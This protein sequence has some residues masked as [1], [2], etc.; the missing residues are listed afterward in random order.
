M[1]EA[2]DSQPPSDNS[3]RHILLSDLMAILSDEEEELSLA[4]QPEP[5]RPKTTTFLDLPPTQSAPSTIPPHQYFAEATGMGVIVPPK[6]PSTQDHLEVMA[7]LAS[8]SG[9]SAKAPAKVQSTNK[10]PTTL[11]MPPDRASVTPAIADVKPERPTPSVTSS[12]PDFSSLSDVT[13]E[14]ST[15]STST[16]PSTLPTASTGEIEN[17]VKRNNGQLAARSTV[18]PPIANRSTALV[19]LT[20]MP[21]EEDVE[22]F[23]HLMLQPKTLAELTQDLWDLRMAML[24]D[25]DFYSQQINRLKQRFWGLIGI[26]S[27]TSVLLAAALGWVIVNF[28]DSQV[29]LARYD[30]AI[31]TNTLLLEELDRST[32]AQL[33]AKVEELQ[34]QVPE[35][36]NEDLTT[37]QTDIATLKT[38]VEELETSVDAHDK[39]L[40]VLV[41]AFQGLVRR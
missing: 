7:V 6:K 36:L 15:S 5:L 16:V 32:M 14:L 8:P 40:S 19:E 27:G 17:E 21:P 31:A 33:A 24:S 30:D 20:A 29:R 2:N 22:R 35:T 37:T 11:D 25:S 12:V 4:R 1:V 34:S 38:Q 28:Q 39:A 18:S 10:S 23:P 41:S 9:E 3:Q 13:S 26:A